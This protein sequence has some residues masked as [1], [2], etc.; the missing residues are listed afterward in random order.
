[1][2]GEVA[3]KAVHWQ[4]PTL[5]RAKRGSDFFLVGLLVIEPHAVESCYQ[6]VVR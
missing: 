1:M 4:V 5:P 3:D 2:N 6:L